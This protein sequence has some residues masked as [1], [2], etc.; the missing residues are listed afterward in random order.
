MSSNR[1]NAGE[2]RKNNPISFSPSFSL[3]FLSLPLSFVFFYF[4]LFSPFPFSFP[5]PFLF[6][7]PST[8]TSPIYTRFSICMHFHVSLTW[9][10]M[11]PTCICHYDPNCHA[12]CHPTPIASKNMKFRLSHN[13]T[14]FTWETRFRETNSA[15][16]SVLSSVI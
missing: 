13:L 16:R 15:V 3:P 8:N 6:F 1:R 5:L 2:L 4:F 14:K 10:A 11:F 7:P 12:M 9:L